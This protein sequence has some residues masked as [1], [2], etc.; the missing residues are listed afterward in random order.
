[1]KTLIAAFLML[2]ACVG[3]NAQ[4]SPQKLD[5]GTQINWP[6]CTGSNQIYSITSNTCVALSAG[7]PAG[8][9]GQ[10]QYNNAGVFGAWT[11]AQAFSNIV[12]PGGTM[13]GPVN[14]GTLY[15]ISGTTGDICS[16]LV[17]AA[18]AL[19]LTGGII[20]AT[21]WSGTASCATDPGPSIG[22]LG[23]GLIVIRLG[24]VTIPKTLTFDSPIDLECSPGAQYNSGNTA[25]TATGTVIEGEISFQGTGANG[26]TIHNCGVDVGSAVTSGLYGGT[27]QDGISGGGALGAYT[28]NLTIN[29]NIVLGTTATAAHHDII[30]QGCQNSLIE[31]N[32]TRFN[33]WGWALKGNNLLALNNNGSGHGS[34]CGTFTSDS[35][36]TSAYDIGRGNVCNA[37]TAGDTWG[38]FLHAQDADLIAPQMLNT[39]VGPGVNIAIQIYGDINQSGTGNLCDSSH[40][41]YVRNVVIDGLQATGP[42]PPTA[43]NPAIFTAGNIQDRVIRNAQLIGWYQGVEDYFGSASGTTG[44]VNEIGDTKIYN[45]NSLMPSQDGMDVSG[46]ADLYGDSVISSGFCGY[47]A[48]NGGTIYLHDSLTN[49]ALCQTGSMGNGSIQGGSFFASATFNTPSSTSGV[50]NYSSFITDSSGDPCLV[51]WL[52]TGTGSNYNASRIC[53]GNA[54]SSTGLEFS[55]SANHPI[56]SEVWTLNG[57]M[58]SGEGFPTWETPS[59]AAYSWEIQN[60]TGSTNLFT[61]DPSGNVV[62]NGTMSTGSATQTIYRCT[63]AGTLPVGALTTATANCGASADTGLRTQ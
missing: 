46:P 3:L 60:S 54:L 57:K 56:G 40:N 49:A 30:C 36:A 38:Y 52:Y 31:N 53:L 6:P 27:A 22:A 10:V 9:S 18:T 32:T 35:Y 25:L 4:S 59:G 63:T 51:E 1:M 21:G 43:N 7:N 48:V 37:V 16:A 23:K 11:Q 14:T 15:F 29:G 34:G 44:P 58:V 24:S 50:N 13:T 61:V 8:S 45:V 28:N 5:P 41:C 2:C 33:T 20:D 19:P 42:A 12:A 55:S 26:S 47:K 39:T 17:T 62:L